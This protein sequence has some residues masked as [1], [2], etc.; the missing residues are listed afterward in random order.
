MKL[1]VLSA[2]AD[3]LVPVS[4]VVYSLRNVQYIEIAASKDCC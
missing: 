3:I 1:S 4:F 2:P